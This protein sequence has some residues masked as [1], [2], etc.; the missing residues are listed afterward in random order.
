LVDRYRQNHVC[1]MRGKRWDESRGVDLSV[2]PK[3]SGVTLLLG[4]DP[5]LQTAYGIG[6]V[7]K[8]F[9]LDPTWMSVCH[10]VTM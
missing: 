2:S 6:E 7:V 5:D 1:K 9:L 8:E 3:A 4:Q 10:D